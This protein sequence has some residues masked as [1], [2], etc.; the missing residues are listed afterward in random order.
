MAY[1]NIDKNTFENVP[2]KTAGVKV[3]LRRIEYIEGHSGAREE[4]FG[5]PEEITLIIHINTRTF[6]M[7]ETGRLEQASSFAASKVG[8]RI[9]RGDLIIHQDRTY[10]TNNAINYGGVYIYSELYLW[11]NDIPDTEDINETAGSNIAPEG[12]FNG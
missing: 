12:E 10:R 7:G 8:D 3:Q 2:L 5:Q 9:K 11:E 6:D 4:T 1:A